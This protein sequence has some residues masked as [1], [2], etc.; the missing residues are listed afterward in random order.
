MLRNSDEMNMTLKIIRDR[1]HAT[2]SYEKIH[3]QKDPWHDG[4]KK[5]K[6]ES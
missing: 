1:F 6:G 4:L 3:K 5:T 2:F